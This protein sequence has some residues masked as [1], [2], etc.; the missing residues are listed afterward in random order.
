MIN[1]SFFEQANVYAEEKGMTVEDVYEVFKKSLVNSFKK[2]YG[3]TSCRVVI[4]PDRNEILL[5]SVHKVVEAYSEELDPE[6]MAE[7]LLEDAKKVKNY[8]KIGDIVEQQINI[9][10]FSRSAV[11]AAKS[12]YTQGIRTKQRELAFDYFKKLENEMTTGVVSNITEKFIALD[13]G[14]NVTATLSI[15]EL[16]PNDNLKI[17]DTIRV[18]I[19][20]VE[21]TTKDPK[22]LVSRVDRQ[23]VTRLME[24]FI[25][26]IKDGTIEIKGIAR[27]PG[28]RSKIALF[29]NDPN[30]DAIGSCVGEGG[31]RIREIVNALGGEKVDLYKWSENPEELI[32]NSL[33]PA[34]VFRVLKIDVKTK[35]S[36]VIVPDDHLSLAIGKQGQNVR[37]AV[38][39]SGWKIDIMPLT[40]AF[41]N[42]LISI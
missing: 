10:N 1:K 34:N 25:P 21:N 26:E 6:A 7:I 18:Y 36:V 4:N 5:Y 16:L 14:M 2:A 11:G 12:V 15:N 32:S 27:D 19:K 24:N 38:Q 35:S 17:G 33:Q 37:L 13:L 23:L 39:S 30:V 8:Y 41:K 9:K 3:H 20:K 31:S 22:V 29:S 40:E 28:D 42:D